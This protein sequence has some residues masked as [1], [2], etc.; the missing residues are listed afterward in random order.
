M[1]F[2]VDF[3]VD[4]DV[5]FAVYLFYSFPLKKKNMSFSIRSTQDPMATSWG[6]MGDNTQWS[7]GRQPIYFK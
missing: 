6:P 7:D 3:A 1:D 5:D 4:F 2:G